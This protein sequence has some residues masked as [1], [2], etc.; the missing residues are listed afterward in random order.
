MLSSSGVSTATRRY[1]KQR[2][3]A[4]K[5]IA[6]IAAAKRTGKSVLGLEMA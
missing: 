1:P 2:A 3:V 4:L 5:N 6:R